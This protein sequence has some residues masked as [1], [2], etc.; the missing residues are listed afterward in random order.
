MKHFTAIV[1]ALGA[2]AYLIEAGTRF[3]GAWGLR[4]R[5]EDAIALLLIAGVARL[6]WSPS[7]QP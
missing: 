4:P 5:I 7:Q 2:L 1:W 3:S 6:I